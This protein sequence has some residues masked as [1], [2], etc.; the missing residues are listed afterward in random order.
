L[1]FPFIFIISQKNQKMYQL[2]YKPKYR[3]TNLKE[4]D[5]FAS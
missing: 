1:K 3:Y 4:R 2:S 5:F